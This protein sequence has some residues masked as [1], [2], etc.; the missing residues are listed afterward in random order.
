PI[1]PPTPATAHAISAAPGSLALVGMGGPGWERGSADVE[2]DRC[3]LH[4]A[5]SIISHWPPRP[6]FVQRPSMNKGHD[7]IGIARP[8]R[9][10]FSACCSRGV[11]IASCRV[12]RRENVRGRRITSRPQRGGDPMS[13]DTTIR[14][15]GLAKS[16][17]E[18]LSDG[19]F[20]I[21]MTLLVLDI[22]VPTPSEVAAAGGLAPVLLALWPRF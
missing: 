19:V 17:I 2:R 21:A 15:A 14:A 20:S 6:P 18:A 12:L 4:E 10:G 11:P 22:R 8:P 7:L 3:H 13:I 9:A 1:P 5:G 16:R